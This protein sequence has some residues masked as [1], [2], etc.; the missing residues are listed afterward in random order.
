MTYNGNK[1][2]IS[3]EKHGKFVDMV[4]NWNKLFKIKYGD[5]RDAVE[6]ICEEYNSKCKFDITIK[7]MDALKCIGKFDGYL[8]SADEDNLIDNELCFLL[9]N[10]D[11]VSLVK[12]RV[13][14]I[15]SNHKQLIWDELTPNILPTGGYAVS[16]NN[17][18]NEYIELLYAHGATQYMFNSFV[19]I[20]EEPLGLIMVHPSSHGVLSKLSSK[21]ELVSSVNGFLRLKNEAILKPRY[22]EPYKKIVDLYG[23]L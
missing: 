20:C 4:G 16:T 3:N 2:E 18:I 23:S 8:F 17:G 6:S 10:L 11:N 7:H 5:F 15:G 21:E 12:W 22:K 19:Q 9:R 13:H 14:R 1:S